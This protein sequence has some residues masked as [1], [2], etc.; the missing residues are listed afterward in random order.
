MNFVLLGHN[1]V[2]YNIC[3]V[4]T[5]QTRMFTIW[6]RASWWRR[7]YKKLKYEIRKH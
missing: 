3:I 1:T 6:N 5:N 2:F 4:Y 7:L